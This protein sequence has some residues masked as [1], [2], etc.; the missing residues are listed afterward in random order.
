MI[1]NSAD[2]RG[3]KQ[4]ADNTIRPLDE[5]APEVELTEFQRCIEMLR[6]EPKKTTRSRVTA[7]RAP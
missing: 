4:L 7:P 1:Q 3:S 2:Q 5:N 6:L